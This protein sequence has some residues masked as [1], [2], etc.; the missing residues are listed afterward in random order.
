MNTEL[1]K[2]TK[3]IIAKYI[4]D[5]CYW[6][7]TALTPQ[8]IIEKINDYT[9]AKRIFNA[10]LQSS[11]FMIR[12]LAIFD[13]EIRKKLILEKSKNLGSFNKQYLK[14]RID[15]LINLYIDS[16]YTTR[17]RVWN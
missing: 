14:R 6:G 11:T 12:D 7:N 16:S 17:K 1:S 2:K 4:L 3:L 8:E 10:I 5:D 13:D 15:S 9:F